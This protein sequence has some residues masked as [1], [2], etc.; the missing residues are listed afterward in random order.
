MHPDQA[1]KQGS[2][3]SRPLP[4]WF[5]AWKATFGKMDGWFRRGG[6]GFVT[7]V[8][9]VVMGNQIGLNYIESYHA[10]TAIIACLLTGLLAHLLLVFLYCLWSGFFLDNGWILLL[11][12][13]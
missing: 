6:L 8:L 2:A 10:C 5:L 12:F 1:R 11:F 3:T 7:G 4:P 9:V 13:L